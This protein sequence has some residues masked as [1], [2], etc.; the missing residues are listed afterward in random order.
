MSGSTASHT[1]VWVAVC[2]RFKSVDLFFHSRGLWGGNAVAAP[3][4]FELFGE[5]WST[6]ALFFAQADEDGVRDMRL[7]RRC[8]SVHGHCRC[9]CLSCAVVY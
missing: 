9:P 8:P 4:H 3:D 5:A 6:P 2:G 1:V 7:V